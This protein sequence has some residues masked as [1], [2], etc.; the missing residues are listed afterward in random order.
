MQMKKRCGT[1]TFILALTLQYSP[2]QAQLSAY[3]VN[4]REEQNTM[5]FP[6]IVEAL[7]SSF[8]KAPSQAEDDKKRKEEEGKKK[9]KNS[10]LTVNVASEQRTGDKVRCPATVRLENLNILRY[11]IR[12]GQEVTFPS[13][14]DLKLPF[15]PPIP[16][17][18]TTGGEHSGASLTGSGPIPSKFQGYQLEL[19]TIENRVV[20]EVQNVITEAAT[21]ANNAKGKLE[22]LISSSDSVLASSSK[23]SVAGAK[24]L[25]NSIRLVKEQITT[26][27]SKSYPDMAIDTSLDK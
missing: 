1:M 8:A 17:K 7:F 2:V 20:S 26:A 25:I 5:K 13:A 21:V 22:A 15:I 3:A 24:A 12:I 11:D 4:S 9:K 19:V 16:A 6:P 14:P 23:D 10:D 27:L 18:S